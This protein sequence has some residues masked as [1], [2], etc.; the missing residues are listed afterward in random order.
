[1]FIFPW[2]TLND[3]IKITSNAS[4]EERLQMKRTDRMRYM[5]VPFAIN[6]MSGNQYEEKQNIS[7]GGISEGER[8]TARQKTQCKE[9]VDG[10]MIFPS[11]WGIQM[12]QHDYF[13]LMY[14]LEGSVEQKIENSTYIYKKGQACFINRNTKHCEI[15]GKDFSVV[16][17]CLSKEYVRRLIEMTSNSSGMIYRFLN[18][19]L[20]EKATYKK[21]YLFLNAFQNDEV[22][23]CTCYLFE[24]M[25]KE[26]E[27][28]NPGY[29]F[30]FHGLV[31]RVL[32]ILQ[33]KNKYQLL[34]VSLGSTVEEILFT[35]IKD[36]IEENPGKCSR[37]EIST[38]LNYSGDYLNRIV[39]KYTGFNIT[40]YCQ[41]V[42]LNETK[43]LLRE[44]N[45]SISAI[46]DKVGFKN[47][48]YFYELF[49][50]EF[51]VL[52]SEYRKM[53]R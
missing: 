23:K 21:D 6:I 2:Y 5:N 11:E 29:L 47:H 36:F 7:F 16:Y 3:Q 48:S 13:E 15:S 25:A 28:K 49:K 32:N 14:V 38:K 18:S 1:M 20:Q 10:K 26:L 43:R 19:N 45:M 53:H 44:G 34:Y 51:G 52:P 37:Q 50:K 9:Q 35:R 27:E 46:I 41:K 31:E 42:A 8:F 22:I 24:K 12:H 33:D 4:R 39:K 17:L 30:I 40:Q